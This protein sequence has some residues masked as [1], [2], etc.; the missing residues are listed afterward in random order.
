[1]QPNDT[2]AEII[3]EQTNWF[4]ELPTV[5][6]LQVICVH[7]GPKPNHFARKNTGFPWELAPEDFVKMM[8][9]EV[10]LVM[11]YLEHRIGVNDFR[12]WSMDW[13]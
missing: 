6:E 11:T 2:Q 10:A 4:V 5:Q 1:M 12:F 13:N 8:L 9:E 7:F 3:R